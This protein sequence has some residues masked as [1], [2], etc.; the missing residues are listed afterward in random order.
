[1]SNITSDSA[2]KAVASSELLQLVTFNLSEEE[3]AVDILNIQGINRMMA[4]TR[5]PNSAHFVEGIINLRGQVIPVIDLRK[6][7]SMPIKQA[8]RESRIIVV[9]IDEKVVGF[10]VDRVNEVLR[11][12]SSITEAPPAMVTGGVDSEFITAV[13]KLEDRLITL[14]DLQK[15]LSADEIN[16]L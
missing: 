16:S 13:A 4:I 2:A 5:V 1:M 9:E 3:Y 11:V 6:R 7:L 8:D 14:L 15:L 12:S 10:I